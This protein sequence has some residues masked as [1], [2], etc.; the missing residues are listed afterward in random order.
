MTGEKIKPIVKG[1]I[2][3]IPGMTEVLPKKM[4]TGGTIESKYCYSVWMRHLINWNKHYRSIPEKVAELGPGDSLGTGLAALLSGSK[5]LYAL[6]VIQFWDNKRNLEIFEELVEYFKNKLNIPDHSDYPKVKPTLDHYSFPSHI[7]SDN[8][9]KNALVESRL[10]AI[11]KEIMDIH[12][13]NNSFIKCFIPWHSSEIIQ[14]NAVDFIYSQAVLQH[15][16]DLENTYYA[17]Q[18]W[19]K[20]AGLTSHSIDFKSMGLTQTWNGHWTFSDLEWKIVKGKKTYLINRLPISKYLEFH[21][22][23][24]LE[25][26]QKEPYYMDNKLSKNQMSPRFRNLSG[27]DITT[28][29]VYILAKKK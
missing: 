12:N 3:L 23:Y 25:I 17:M 5:C 6:D 18:Q 7:L 29:G 1:L 8:I 20:P 14:N 10:N 16:N 4:E 21:E 26:L 24:G 28:S 9:L 2:K 13:P 27:E 22:K 11:R 19:L 15:V